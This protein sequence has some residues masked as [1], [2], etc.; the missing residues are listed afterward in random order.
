MIKS[1][2]KPD[3]KLII[4]KITQDKESRTKNFYIF[5]LSLN[6]E[7][8]KIFNKKLKELINNY[9]QDDDNE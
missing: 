5:G 9:T 8:E 3:K 7:Q 1:Y 4:S 6:D 2:K